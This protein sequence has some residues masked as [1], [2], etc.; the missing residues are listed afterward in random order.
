LHQIVGNPTILQAALL[1]GQSIS[2]P[3]DTSD[4]TASNDAMS[5]AS[6]GMDYAGDLLSHEM[7]TIVNRREP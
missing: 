2:G 1:Q 5:T 6:Y 3:E 4:G 7:E